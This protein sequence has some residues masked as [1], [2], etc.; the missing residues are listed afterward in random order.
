MTFT[1]SST[2]ENEQYLSEITVQEEKQLQQKRVASSPGASGVKSEVLPG[3]E[4]Q[5][6]IPSAIY[7]DVYAEE[8][9]LLFWKSSWKKEGTIWK[10]C[11]IG[12]KALQ[13]VFILW[14]YGVFASMF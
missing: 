9:P 11:S 12:C 6:P 1:P 4:F 13:M 5:G 14:F 10:P 2:A 3:Q 7:I 8:M